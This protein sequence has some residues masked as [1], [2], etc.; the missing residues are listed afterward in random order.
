MRNANGEGTVLYSKDRKKFIWRG[1][2]VAPDGNRI[3]KAIQADNRKELNQKVQEWKNQLQDGGINLYD[4]MTL[5]ELAEVW[6]SFKRGT[7]AESTWKGYDSDLRAHI[8]PRFG[9]RKIKSLNA[10][11]IQYWLNSLVAKSSSRTV[12]RIRGTFRNLI[13]FA[14]EQ[15]LTRVNIMRGV[16]SIKNNVDPI[17]IPSQE[18]VQKLLN[19]AKS[20]K[21]YNF[22]EDDFGHYLQQEVF[23]IVMIAVRTGMR[24]SEILALQWR[25]FDYSQKTIMVA[26]SLNRSGQLTPPK[27]AKSRRVIL[28]DED[29]ARLLIEWEKEQTEYMEKYEGI[30]ANHQGMIFTTQVGTP[31]RYDNFRFRYWDALTQMAGLP[32]LHF[33]SLRHFT[34][35]TLLAAGIPSKAVSELLGHSTTR[36]TIEVYQSVV[37]ETRQQIIGIIEKLT[38]KEAPESVAALSEAEK[39]D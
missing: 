19:V 6:L 22:T 9:K 2:F 28:L 24:V 5:N 38:K 16:K 8:L 34:A 39:N 17:R 36:T 30:V 12:N 10:V 37:P 15:G 27:T 20:G 25:Y 18:E 23:L 14:T 31:M 7:I 32:H 4:E 35:T 21:Y 29:T 1:F 26:H 13:T 33:H 11:E 3:R